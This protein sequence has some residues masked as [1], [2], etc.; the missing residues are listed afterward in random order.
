MN[1]AMKIA[2]AGRGIGLSEAEIASFA[3]ALSSVG[4]ES[5]AG[6]SAFSR[7]MTKMQLAVEMG[8][9]DLANFAKVSGMSAKKFKEAFQTDAAGAI[10]AFIKG[11]NSGGEAGE[12]ATKILADMEIS[13]LRVTDALKR[14]AIANDVFTDALALGETA[15]A[16]NNALAEEAGKRY[17]TT[18]SMIAMMKNSLSDM[19]ITVG[20]MLLPKIKELVEK[21]AGVIPKITEWIAANGD[22]IATVAKVSVGLFAAKTAFLGVKAAVLGVIGVIKAVKTVMAAYKLAQ[23]LMSA[24]TTAW[25]AVSTAAAGPTAALGA[26]MAAVSWPVLAVVA[27]VAAVI[28]IV[29][30]LVKHWD[31]VKEV[32]SKIGGWLN[33]NVIQPVIR[34]FGPVVEKFKEIFSTIWQII[35]AVFGAAGGWFREKFTEAWMAVKAVFAP[36]AE[37]FS[38]LWDG[39]KSIFSK[40]GTAVGEAVSGAFKSVVNAIISFAEDKVNSFI[41]GIN[42]VVGIVN[43]LP[44]V[45]IKTIELL[46][47]PRLAKGS[48]YTPDTFIAGERGAELIAGAGGRKVFTAAETGKIFENLNRVNGA[49][50][51]PAPTLNARNG[52][53]YIEFRP[54]YNIT[55]NG[56]KAGDLEGQLRKHDELLLAELER[57]L[58]RKRRD[59]V[60]LAYA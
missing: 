28:A 31:K 5:A 38:G 18:E 50:A 45:S 6:G 47:I 44:G 24:G 15:W 29:V 48:E 33:D 43:N 1:M 49:G 10:T 58:E 20:D 54:E 41:K 35:T 16:E 46:E 4:L 23:A 55:V 52:D 7:V 11:L 27:A 56:D 17:A 42:A 2:A 39:I 25:A 60:R 13:E 32:F 3:G 59:E 40:I 12:S 19:A 53:R 36:F 34:V 8:N 37:F 26:A 9:G 57:R 14:A 30:L 51:V 22:V 21:M